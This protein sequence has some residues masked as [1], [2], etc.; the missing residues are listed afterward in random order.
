M[1]LG[2]IDKRGEV[3][4]VLGNIHRR[5]FANE[6]KTFGLTCAESFPDE[7]ACHYHSANHHLDH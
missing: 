3:A 5:V 1:V 6:V 2:G 4:F 7:D